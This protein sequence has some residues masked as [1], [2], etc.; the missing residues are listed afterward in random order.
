VRERGLEFDL[1]R[2]EGNEVARSFGLVHG[3]PD[4]LRDVY[5]KLGI[6]LPEA[7]AE[8]SWT[9]PMPARYIVDRSGAIRYARVHPDYRTR[10][11]PS[12]TLEALRQ[13]A[14]E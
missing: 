8:P 11:A 1:L 13:I 10:P 5:R 12:D 2:D 7:N 3:F 14:S 6:D 9:L 4:E